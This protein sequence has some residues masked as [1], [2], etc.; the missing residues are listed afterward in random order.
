MTLTGQAR[1]RPIRRAR[2]ASMRIVLMGTRGIPAR[3][4]GFETAVQEIG[5]RLVER[6]HEVTVYCRDGADEAAGEY[7]GMRLVHL[8]AVHSKSLETLSHTGLSTAHALA[9]CRPDVAVLFNAANAPFVPVLRARGIPVATHVDGLEWKRAKWAGSGR[10]YYLIA[11]RLA[12]RWSDALIADAPGIADYYREKFGAQTQLISYGAPILT[13]SGTDHLDRIGVASRKYHLAV[14]RFEPENHVDVVVDGYL[15]SQADGPLLVVGSAPYAGEYTAKVRALAGRNEQVRLIGPVWD[16][17]EL[18]QLYAHALTYVHG[19]SVGGTN[20]SLL[21]A[22]G[23]ATAVCAYDVAFNREVLGEHG[24][25]FGDAAT[26]ATAFNRAEA[27][28]AAALDRGQHLQEVARRRYRWDD[29]ADRY[30]ELCR[31]L[32]AKRLRAT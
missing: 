28:P 31:D 25:Y 19:H 22:I 13:D 21:R 30:E 17:R 10:R 11:E 1:A 9:R 27:D 3:Y 6:G 24:R 2:T 23:A 29:V 26:L 4:G 5:R 20:P 18:D 16:Q 32:V 15:R 8:P 7:L 12:V 14:A